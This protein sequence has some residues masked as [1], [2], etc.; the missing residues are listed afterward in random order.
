M[1]EEK[2]D[3]IF[4]KA[5]EL[6]DSDILQRIF[7]KRDVN[8]AHDAARLYASSIVRNKLT[9]PI[10]QSKDTYWQWHFDEELTRL[11]N[12]KG[13]LLPEHLRKRAELGSKRPSK[14]KGINNYR[15][16]QIAFVVMHLCDI[17]GISATRNDTAPTESACD[18][19]A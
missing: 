1:T 4:N 10:P 18:I 6:F 5:R 15:N 14:A 7:A 13:C 2:Y 9:N 16:H 3:E 17:Y 12:A 11:L 8:Q 19:V